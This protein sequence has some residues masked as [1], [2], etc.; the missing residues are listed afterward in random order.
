MLPYDKH[1]L[2]HEIHLVEAQ[3]KKQRLQKRDTIVMFQWLCCLLLFLFAG[4]SAHEEKIYCPYCDEII[5]LEVKQGTWTCPKKSCGYEN[6]NRIRY[7]GMC[8]GE[9]Q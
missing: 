1:Y 4:L 3:I 5:E 8:G 7:C 2:E 6:D 9:R